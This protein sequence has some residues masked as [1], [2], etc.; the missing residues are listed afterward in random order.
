VETEETA[1]NLNDLADSCD[2]LMR[3]VA[4]VLIEAKRGLAEVNA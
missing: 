4:R 2:A 3:A 1:R